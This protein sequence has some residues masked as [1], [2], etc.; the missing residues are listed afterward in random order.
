MS[1]ICD[2]ISLRTQKFLHFSFAYKTIESEQTKNGKCTELAKLNF[3]NFNI[4][5]YQSFVDRITE[6]NMKLTMKN[7]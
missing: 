2:G 6:I 7:L 1:K 4:S 3:N 5:F